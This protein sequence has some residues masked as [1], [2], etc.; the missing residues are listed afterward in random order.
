MEFLEHLFSS[1]PNPVGDTK[2]APMWACESP[3]GQSKKLRNGYGGLRRVPPLAELLDSYHHQ[4]DSHGVTDHYTDSLANFCTHITE[5]DHAFRQVKLTAAGMGR[6]Q[7][8]FSTGDSGF[9][10]DYESP[11]ADQKNTGAIPP[12]ELVENPLDGSQIGQE[13]ERV[14][15]LA[16]PLVGTSCMDEL[17]NE[18][19]MPCWSTAVLPLD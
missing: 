8:G 15:K 2:A 16:A 17:L 5:T 1:H 11:E 3:L 7:D 6:D 14:E 4:Y 13:E 19:P 10:G 12:F 18:D 9:L